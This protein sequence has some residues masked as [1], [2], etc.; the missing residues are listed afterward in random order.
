MS[1]PQPS[2]PPPARGRKVARHGLNPRP[3]PRPAWLVA[4]DL[5]HE[6][7]QQEV[8]TAEDAERLAAELRER[9][10]APGLGDAE[11]LA[12][13]ETLEGYELAAQRLRRKHEF[14]GPVVLPYD[15]RPTCGA[16]NRRGEPCRARVV[17]DEERDLPRN[18]RCKS[19]GGLSTGPRT[20]E[21]RLRCAEARREAA[22]RRA[23]E[24]SPPTSAPT[25]PPQTVLPAPMHLLEEFRGLAESCRASLAQLEAKFLEKPTPALNRRIKSTRR[26]LAW[27]ESTVRALE[28]G[29]WPTGVTPA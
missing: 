24:K 10:A 29:T 23:E 12:L 16:K 20:D 9:I 14:Q 4:R 13:L 1:A 6:K 11:N 18:G 19:H 27:A 28:S 8:E 26:Q 7:R 5:A 22:R 17:W 21:G 25:P 3:E 15:Q 2:T